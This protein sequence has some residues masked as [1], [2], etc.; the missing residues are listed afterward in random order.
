MIY[1][2]GDL[3]RIYN[4]TTGYC[5]ICRKKLAFKNYGRLGAKAPWEVEHS[6]PRAFGGT[7]RYSNLYAACISCNRNKGASSTA[8][9]RR[10]HGRTCAPLSRDDR[11]SAKTG[12]TVV[13]AGLA[14]LVGRMLSFTPGGL[15]LTALLGAYIANKANPDDHRLAG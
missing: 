15:I 7:D 10:Q 12:N 14:L 4:R 11:A 5:H 13:G 8:S 6:N 3:R 9:A 1:T 2:Q